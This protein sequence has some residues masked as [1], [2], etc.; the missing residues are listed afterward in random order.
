[1]P[2]TKQLLSG[3][4]NGRG[5]KIAATSGTGTTIHTCS[6]S[7]SDTDEIWL[8][9]SNPDIVSHFVIIQF[10]GTTTIDDEIDLYV[11][12]YQGL[13]LAV[14]GLI[15]KGNATPPVVRAVVDIAN[16]VTVMG[17]VNRIS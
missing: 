16:T 13:Y 3:S 5:I 12:P 2:I 4:T 8:Y 6:T 7:T 11:N 17:Y 9:L 15:L 1:M 14:P 10:G